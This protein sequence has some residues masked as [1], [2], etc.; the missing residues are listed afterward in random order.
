MLNY[1]EQLNELDFHDSNIESMYIEDADYFDRRLTVLI[2]YYNWEGN[3]EESDIWKTKVLKI[4]INHC[5]HLQLNAPN[6][7]EDTFEIVD[8]EFDV[9]FNEFIEKAIEEKGKSYFV[10][11]KSK[12][13]SNFL[14]LKFYTRNY[15]DSLFDEHAGFIWIAGFNVTHEWI[16]AKETVKKH[17][18]IK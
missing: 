12:E 9:K 11:L 13:L 1:R 6:L 4:T 8:H 5:V 18:A 14:S 17:I 16:D 3:K 7:M 15:A 10:H 2:D